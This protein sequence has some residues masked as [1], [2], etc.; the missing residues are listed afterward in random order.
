MIRFRKLILGLM[1]T[2]L[3]SI[4]YCDS[5]TGPDSHSNS[6]ET[7]GTV[8]TTDSNHYV[9]PGGDDSCSGCKG[10]LSSSDKA[11]IEEELEKN[12][13]EDA[14]IDLNVRITIPKS[15]NPEADSDLDLWATVI[16]PAGSEKL[17]TIV[18]ATPYRREMCIMMYIPLVNHRYNLLAVDLR[19]TGSSEGTW[20]SFDLVEQYDA[21]YVIDKFI[22]KQVWSDGK[23]GMI[24]PSYMGII[25][26][27]TAGLVETDPVTG[28]PVHLKALFPL[29]PKS[30][31]YRDIVM[32]GGNIDLLFIPIWLGFVDMLAV[33][34]SA[35]NLG[36][37]G[38][39]TEETIG[40][41]QD[42]WLTHW[43][44]VPTTVGWIMDIDHMND[45]PF[46][47]KKSAMQYWPQK[48]AGGWG[49]PEGDRVISSKLPVFLTSGW[50]DLFTRGTTNHYQ[51][52]LVNHSTSDKRIVIGEWY[53]IGGSAGLGLDSYMTCSLAA[54]WF[55]WKIKGKQDPF[56]EEFPVLLYVM[57]ENKWRAE[58]AWPLPADR[59]VNR[60]LYLTKKAPTPIEGDWYTDADTGEYD[61][62]NYGMNNQ[63][64]FEGENP[65]LE[66]DVFSLTGLDL[67]GMKSRSSTRWAAGGF[68]IVSD[69][70]KFY[71]NTNIDASQWYED[72]RNDE[73]ECLTFTTEPLT[74]DVDITG[75]ISVTFWARTEFKAALT[76][77]TVNII[78]ET[79]KNMYNVDSN[80]I[81]G[82]MNK[83]DV[84]WVA[85]VNDVFPDGR[86]RNVASGW[87][88]AWHRT[89]DPSGKTTTCVLDG[90]TVVQHAIDPAYV[91]FDPFYERPDKNPKAI[92]EGELYQYTVELW[93]T[94][95][96]FKKGNRIRVS[97]SA[98][99]F[100]HMV[101]IL[102][103]SRNTIVIDAK[104]PATVK[105]TSTTREN[106]GTSWK[107]VGSS[108]DTDDYLMSGGPISC[109]S[110][111]SAS[112]YRG[113][114]AGF[115]A[116]FLGIL[117]IMI[118]PLSLIALRNH[119]RKKVIRK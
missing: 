57:G 99:D 85:E 64:D 36:I 52:G 20:E 50:F 100:P 3:I 83:K 35:L 26:M 90:K 78:T 113:T 31:A 96:V 23:V 110:S 45:G 39:L 9:E 95:N 5:G 71:L 11:Q 107:W 63:P 1:I 119:L 108:E 38:K 94:S 19:G 81:L 24:G 14:K 13:V 37:D 97:I 73:K 40:E 48:P 4:L 46:Y 67:H 49:Y 16:R 22:P 117:G 54:R 41:A 33:L 112:E 115:F 7:G 17:P 8:V 32:H 86:A 59:V 10:Q 2:G 28:E 69:L 58:K 104:H 51:Y 29:V 34:P 25:Q 92:N 105:F 60:T 70:S 101:P 106:E 21:R 114:K 93:P 98:S 74:E 118:I 79:I 66:H 91:T 111:A 43:N 103:P 68:S 47:D 76:Q 56:M 84:Q 6:E 61:D 27:L 62:N 77:A 55:D 42:T 44:H 109:G 87:L 12:D 80:L 72:E 75:R 82:A 102:R 18:V 65:V 88:S 53:H 15:E 89:Y 30:D 116:E